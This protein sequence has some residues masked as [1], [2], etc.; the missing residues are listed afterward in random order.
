MRPVEND[1]FCR[2]MVT[3]T[4]FKVSLCTYFNEENDE[5]SLDECAYS[6]KW[7]EWFEYMGAMD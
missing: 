4:K 2:Y 3:Q 6:H 5:C 7:L 1:D